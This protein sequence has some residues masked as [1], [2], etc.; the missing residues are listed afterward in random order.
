MKIA[1]IGTNFITVRFLEA[2]KL[3]PEF[4]LAGV[5]ASSQEKAT[6][7]AAN[8]GGVP[9]FGD[10]KELL[11]LPKLDGVYI[12]SPNEQHCPMTLFFL[13]A[14]I[15][16]LCEKPMA[17]TLPQVTQMIE[18][19]HRKN[20]LLLEG[21]VPL[22]IPNFASIR[23]HLPQ[24]G[25]VRQAVLSF[26]QYS[27]RYDNYRKGIVENAFRPEKMGGS[28]MD[29][30]IYPLY[31]AIALWGAPLAVQSTARLLETGIDA[32]GMNILHY[33]DKD[34]VL[35]HSKTTNTCCGSEI[36]GE[37]G[38]ITYHGGSNPITA[39]MRLRDGDDIDIG[40]EQ[41]P[42][43]MYYELAEFLRCIK[44]GETQSPLAPHHLALTVYGLTDQLRK[45]VGVRF[46]LDR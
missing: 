11:T 3:H 6:A 33:G 46:P 34:V 32:S 13:E 23:E 4:S 42:E 19:A 12:A 18:T 25:V 10:Y 5:A 14:G 35:V 30:G 39:A 27:S 45:Q 8:Y 36:Q 7:F 22:F 24:I 29:I 38:C 2:A 15:P 44:D 37:A 17:P 9:A 41:Y 40:K 1:V 20:V 16:V 43:R 31:H 26:C 28:L 21:I